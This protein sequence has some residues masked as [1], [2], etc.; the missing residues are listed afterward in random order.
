MRTPLDRLT[1]RLPNPARVALHDVDRAWLEHEV[2][3]ARVAALGWRVGAEA[4]ARGRSEHAIRERAGFDE[5]VEAAQA[6]RAAQ[7]LDFFLFGQQ[8]NDR[9]AAIRLDFG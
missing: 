5:H 1:Q 9:V 2:E 4:H 3:G 8:I 6:H 7:T